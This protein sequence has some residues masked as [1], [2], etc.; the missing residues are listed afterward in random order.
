MDQLFSSWNA[1][2]C[3]IHEC[4]EAHTAVDVVADIAAL[5]ELIAGRLRIV[6]QGASVV[7]ARLPWPLAI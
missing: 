6:R 1:T 5:R 7:E 2:D 3:E 4:V